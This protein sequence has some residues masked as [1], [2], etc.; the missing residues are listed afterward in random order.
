MD[1]NRLWEMFQAFTDIYAPSFKE[2][3][4]GDLLKTKLTKLGA[5]LYEDNAGADINGNCGNLYGYL[6]GSNCAGQ[7]PVLFSA[8][9]DTVEP[10]FGKKAV[11]LE[12]KIIVSEG[13]TILGADDAAGICIILE[14]LFRIQEEGMPHRPV[15]LLFPVAEERYGLGSQM[16]E[17]SRIQAK[18]AY[19][20]DLEGAIGEAANAAPTILSFSV[21]VSGKAAH[22]GFQPQNGVHAIAAA[23]KA[24]ARI[25]QGA[26]EPGLTCNI[27][28]ISG[29]ELTNIVPD[30]CVVSGE[31][32]SLSHARALAQWQ[33]IERVFTEE[34]EQAGASLKTEHDIKI[35]A[36]ETPLD[37]PVTRR[38]QKACEMIGVESQIHATMGG[39]DNNVFAQHGIEGLVIAC[40]MHDVHSSGEWSSL[41]E[42]E[43]CTRLVM[44][45]MTQEEQR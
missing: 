16:A 3:Q 26:P 30:R 40:S 39:S 31:I 24:V 4:L 35:T 15:E 20:L 23:A 38:F 2:R 21:T 36:Y 27:G 22:A 43:L 19:V 32:R 17:Y 41:D 44:K 33:E 28:V 34:A 10:A 8:H 37:A 12:D 5:E 11:L 9:M 14:A 6:P 18:E 25:P 7:T 42:M 45:L 29:G 1:K 13:D